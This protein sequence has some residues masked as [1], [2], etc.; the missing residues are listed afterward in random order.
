MPHL[1]EQKKANILRFIE[2]VDEPRIEG[3]SLV[4]DE[5]ADGLFD[6]RGG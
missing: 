3:K 4:E 1:T 6:T 2:Q 5:I